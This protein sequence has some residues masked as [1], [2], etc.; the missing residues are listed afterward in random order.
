MEGGEG[1][2]PPHNMKKSEL[3]PS[4]DGENMRTSE[5]EPNSGRDERGSAAN[6]VRRLSPSII[7]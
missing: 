7:K 1:P 3:E 6:R 5:E 4:R 2:A